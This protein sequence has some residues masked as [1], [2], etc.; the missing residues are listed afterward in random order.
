MKTP[1]VFLI[2][3]IFTTASLMTSAYA[4][5]DIQTPWADVYVGP[6]GVYVYGPWGRVEVPSSDRA[7]VCRNWRKS[8]RNYYKKRGCSVDFDK[9]GCIIEKVECDD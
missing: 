6:D 4:E 1:T 7:R 8:T 2:A 5:V 3:C 9:S